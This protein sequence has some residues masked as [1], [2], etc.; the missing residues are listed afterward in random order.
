VVVIDV[1]V[2]VAL[3]AFAFNVPGPTSKGV[4]RSTP[5]YSI[6]A[7]TVNSVVPPLFETLKF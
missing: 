3:P 4:T 2:T 6:I 7:P 5:E 1:A